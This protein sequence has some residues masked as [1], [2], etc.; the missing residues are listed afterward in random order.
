MADRKEY[1]K[2]YR[3]DGWGRAADYRYRQKHLQEIR[4]KDRIRKML[5][6]KA[7]EG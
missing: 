1:M 5:K 6:R 3:Q 7:R 4:E 2:Q